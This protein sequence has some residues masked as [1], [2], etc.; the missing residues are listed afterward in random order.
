MFPEPSRAIA[1]IP[2]SRL[3]PPRYVEKSRVAPVG[4]NSD[5]TMSDPPAFADCKALAMGKF[6]ELVVPLATTSA[7][8]LTATAVKLSLLV[9]PRYEEYERGGS[10]VRGRLVSYVPRANP[11]TFDLVSTKAAVTE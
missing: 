2:W 11:T 7:D 6:V 10:I 1:P 9:P 8:P 4:S 3:L 5:R